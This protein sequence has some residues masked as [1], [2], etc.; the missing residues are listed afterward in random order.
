MKVSAAVR[1]EG[2]E[3]IAIRRRY[4]AGVSSI[5]SGLDTVDPVEGSGIS[6]IGTAKECRSKNHS[7]RRADAEGSRTIRSEVREA[8]PNRHGVDPAELSFPP[9]G[10]HGSNNFDERDKLFGA[11]AGDKSKAKKGLD[12]LFKSRAADPCT[13]GHAWIRDWDGVNKCARCK[14]PKPM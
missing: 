8:F 6:L 5:D 10:Y 4:T 14:T 7:I 9:M 1:A 13:Q 3:S 11:Q 2:Q 12:D